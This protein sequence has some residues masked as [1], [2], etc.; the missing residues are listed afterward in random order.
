[1][2]I[3]ILLGIQMVGLGALAAFSVHLYRRS[4]ATHAQLAQDGFDRA[5]AADQRADHV[6]ER[7]VEIE[8]RLPRLQAQVEQQALERR[9]DRARLMVLEAQAKSALPAAAAE[10]LTEAL[11]QVANE[12]SP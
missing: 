5:L 9:V 10:R 8:Q 6:V 11:Q 12:T 2:W 7:L 4:Q 1:M 3:A